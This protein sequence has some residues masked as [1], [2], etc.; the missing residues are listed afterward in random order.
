MT[1]VHQGGSDISYNKSHCAHGQR[2][3]GMEPRDWDRP[4]DE[5]VGRGG[6]R[7]QLPLSLVIQK[8]LER[9]ATASSGVVVAGAL[10][11]LNHCWSTTGH[12]R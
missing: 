6:Q 12:P 10:G 9:P 7:G 4:A 1:Y 5:G 8:G 3:V 11:P 2:V